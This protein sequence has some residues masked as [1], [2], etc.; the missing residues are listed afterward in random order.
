MTKQELIVNCS[1][2][3]LTSIPETFPNSTTHLLLN[4]NHLHIIPNDAFINLSHLICL[5]LSNCELYKMENM[6]FHHLL[7]L[8]T[9]ILKNNYLSA[10]NASFP[11]EVF[12]PLQ[13]Q[14][15]TLDI[16]GNLKGLPV[17]F[18][19]YPEKALSCLKSL[20]VLR[21]DCIPNL[22]LPDTLSQMHN[23]TTL[24]FSNGLKVHNVTNDFFIQ[25]Q[26]FQ[27]KC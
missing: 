10:N 12:C 25:F 11:D 24:D 4:N 6:S 15:Q 18:Y 9:L 14:L 13:N 7:N 1:S 20:Q 5:D 2:N 23:L 19:A 26:N 27:L 8:K 16:R 21:I 3:G 17:E 22:N